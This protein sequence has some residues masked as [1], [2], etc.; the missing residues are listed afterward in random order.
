MDHKTTVHQPEV[1]NKKLLDKSSYLEFPCEVCSRT[2]TK[3]QDLDSHMTRHV[4]FICKSC[5]LE[6]R[7]SD[8]L[9]IH[10]KLHLGEANKLKCL[11]CH[12]S[13]PNPEEVVQ[14]LLNN[15]SE[16][17]TPCCSV[18][19]KVFDNEKLLDY[20]M[21]LHFGITPYSCQI[22]DKKF[23]LRELYN[24]HYLNHLGQKPF[25]CLGE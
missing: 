15:H 2:F 8:F 17:E 6:F 25:Q 12:E 5:K 21:R 1:V 23:G 24:V 18:C 14:H 11:K 7:S 22:C 4:R 13:F 20:H 9:K 3:Q 16:P 19:S 10:E